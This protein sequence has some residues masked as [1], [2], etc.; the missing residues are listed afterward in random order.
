MR[1]FEKSYS[2]NLGG[3]FH[4]VST[5]MSFIIAYK[6]LSFIVPK[7]FL[8]RFRKPELTIL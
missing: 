3:Q 2:G 8:C 6:V 4:K 1:N 7:T 5:V